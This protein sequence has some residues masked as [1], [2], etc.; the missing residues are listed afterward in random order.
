MGTRLPWLWCLLTA[1][2]S[3]E[4]FAQQIPARPLITRPI[5]ESQL[6]TLRGNTHP[7]AQPQY[8]VGPVP[9]NFQLQRMLLV[10]KRSAQQDFALRKLLDDQHNK[11][12]PNY[13]KW[14]TPD[15]FG[16]QFG[17]SDSDIQ[18]VTGW[19]ESH[20]LQVA[21]ATRGRTLIEFSGTE[22]QVESALHTQIHR[23]LLPNGEQH[24]A[25]A[26]DPQ[27]PAALTPAVAG[28]VPLND[29][30]RGKPLLQTLGTAGY[31]PA[32]KKTSPLWTNPNG[33][34]NFYALAPGDFATQYDLKPLYQVGVNGAGQTIGIINVSNIDLSLVNAYQQLFG[35]ANNSPQVVI[36]GND[37]GTLNGV[38]V[39]A[40]LDVQVSGAV[41]PN[42]TVNLYIS[43]GG[44]LF[45]PLSFA[46]IRAVE[47]N[48]ASVLSMSFGA[49]EWLLGPSGNQFF[50][51]LWQQAAS[52]GQTVFVSSGD[53]GSAGC[54]P[55]GP[56][57]AQISGLA[58]NGFASTPWN[59][60]VGGTDFYYSD[61][62][63]GA[64][65]ASTY[66]NRTNDSSNGSLIGPLTEQVWNDFFGLNAQNPLGPGQVNDVGGGGGASSCATWDKSGS[67]CVA[68]YPKP[69]W[70]TGLGVPAD[71]VRDLPDL[72]LF[73]ANGANLS[74]YPI[75]AF[76]GACI[77]DS[78]GQVQVLLVGG[79]SAS[80]PAMAGIM[81]LI[82]QKYGRQGQA[83]VVLY[84]LAQ[85]VPSAFHDITL[86]SNNVPCW[87]GSSNS[88]LQD[89]TDNFWSLQNYSASA[90]YDQAS[91]LGSVDANVLVNNWN[92][93]TF[94]P[95]NTSLKLS[96]AT[97]THG[98]AVNVATTVKPTS[99]SGTPSGAVAILTDSPLP[100]NLS[101]FSLGLTN[102]TA[103]GNVTFFPGGSYH[104][105]ANYGGDDVFGMSKSSPV[106]LTV[107]PENS[108]L[109][110]AALALTQQFSS[111]G[112][113]TNGATVSYGSLV[114]LGIRPTG[115]SAPMG[116]TN[117]IATG[118]ATFNLDSAT[119]TVPL[120]SVGLATW[121][122]PTLA[123][124]SHTVNASYSGDSSFNSGSATPI[125]FTVAQGLP[126][127][128]F[129]MP[130]YP[131]LRSGDSI[132]LSATVRA[133]FPGFGTVPTGSITASLGNGTSQTVALSAVN[134][135]ESAAVVTFQNV[136]AGSYCFPGASYSGDA[137]WLSAGNGI[138]GCFGVSPG[139]NTP[140][141]TTL[142]ISPST[143]TGNQ[144]ATF[145]VSVSAGS[146]ATATPTGSIL[147]YDN[148]VYLFQQGLPPSTNGNSTTIAISGIYPSQFVTNGANKIAALYSGSYSYQA[149]TSAPASISVT[150]IGPDFTLAPQRPQVLIKAGS[151][152]TVGL[153][154]SS[155]SGFNGTVNLSCSP[156]SPNLTCSVSPSSLN[157]N[158][159][160]NTVLN[161]NALPGAALHTS[162]AVRALVSHRRNGLKWIN[163]VGI[164]VFAS[165]CLSGF[166]RRRKAALLC[167]SALLASLLLI[168]SC[169]GG[170]Q[171]TVQPP[172]PP[173]PTA[174]NT[175][176]YT[177]LVTGGANGL[178]HNSQ[179]IVAVQ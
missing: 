142:N 151:S 127:M 87:P 3:S 135:Y 117:G 51:A 41:A 156:S 112:P 68:G 34:T 128:S 134:S 65:S 114:T 146:G 158:G 63:L 56:I 69:N 38:D 170:G 105:F 179:V 94:L 2:L 136:A 62:A 16:I 130:D 90:G 101:Q 35:L 129:F 58:V 75:C 177:V 48:Q 96:S 91:G 1:L 108:N 52:Q 83:G 30:T 49:C 53:S 61:Y 12:S 88:C 137:N 141:T 10:L 154:L 64:P 46:A 140:T 57:Q 123:L 178:V 132:T 27:I 70:Q 21:R 97:I 39:E 4:V 110:F 164:F 149:S 36:D 161:I 20:G 109:N 37:P 166:T 122:A 84:P 163:S 11:N 133:P 86:G 111:P 43:D 107:K 74:A 126:V 14:L 50:S 175:T 93:V 44:T 150:N 17:L 159:I 113:I 67:Y 28:T 45:D 118:T 153:N 144:T 157:V 162:S 155:L 167:S 98:Q 9:Q 145:N 82:N 89:N 13:H 85:Q 55:A 25:N 119:Q 99:G 29:F 8:D 42:A 24:W 71:G 124:G 148:G 143:I 169:G 23:Y 40:Y 165:F 22:A 120:D 72:S 60:A 152:G 59:L 171:Q 6:V 7:L 18:Q 19:L 138:D 78:S 174:P 32:T 100:S 176:Y 92:S 81:A 76:S 66:W 33:M 103:S 77:P 47:D 15:E 73:A 95:T 139:T 54:D 80:S 121:P 147:I 115:A 79:T 104:V 131:N 26:I 31:D 172:P 168:T 160:A 116:Q 125:S 173:P 106:V 102:G 5:D